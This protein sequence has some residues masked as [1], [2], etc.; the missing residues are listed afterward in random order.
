[1]VV[2]SNRPGIRRWLAAVIVAAPLALLAGCT[3]KEYP[4]SSLNPHSDYAWII[5]HLLN[6][7]VFWVLIIF[8]LVQVLLIYTVLRFRSRPG[9]PEPKPVHGNTALEIA[10]TVAPAIILALIA[11]PTVMAIFKTQGAPG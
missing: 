8:T 7:L 2:R 11:V 3:L 5:Q 10:W 6:Q 1:M 4:Q 9:A